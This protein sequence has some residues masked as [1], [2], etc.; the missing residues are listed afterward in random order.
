M[1]LIRGINPSQAIKEPPNMNAD[2]SV[3]TINPTPS[4]EARVSNPNIE[5]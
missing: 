2:A 5:L 3:P 4:N 1:N